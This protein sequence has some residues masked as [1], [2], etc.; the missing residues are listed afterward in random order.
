MAAQNV[1]T[2]FLLPQIPCTTSFITVSIEHVKAEGLLWDIMCVG[3]SLEWSHEDSSSSSSAFRIREVASRCVLQCLGQAIRRACTGNLNC[4]FRNL[5]CLVID[6]ADRCLEIG[7]EEE[8]KK[9]LKIL[10]ATRQTM[11]FSATQTKDIQDLAKL[12]FQSQ[13]IYLGVDD[14][15]RTT[16]NERLEQGYVVVP[17]DKRFLLLFTF[18]KKNRKKKVRCACHRVH[19]P[20]LLSCVKDYCWLLSLTYCITLST[21]VWVWTLKSASQ[22]CFPCHS[23]CLMLLRQRVSA[24]KMAWAV[25]EPTMTHR[26]GPETCMACRSWSSFLHATRSSST[27]SFSTLS[28]SKCLISTVSR[29]S[30]SAPAHS[31]NSLKLRREPSCAQTLLHADWTYLQLTG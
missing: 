6:E 31:L 30:R 24:C 7:F 8:M 3:D 23:L 1:L 16:T 22:A 2:R 9:I 4:L 27:L 10:P 13:P 11:L 28:T 25:L 17:S 5:A 15:R 14:E 26:H 20:A 12:S 21:I 19:P 29:S 18:L